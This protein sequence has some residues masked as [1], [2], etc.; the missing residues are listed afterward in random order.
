M[1]F[2]HVF[3][4]VHMPRS[5]AKIRY[6]QFG[7]CLGI[8]IEKGSQAPEETARF[9]GPGGSIPGARMLAAK[10]VVWRSAFCCARSPFSC[11]SILIPHLH[12]A[13]PYARA[14]ASR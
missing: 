8:I 3:L 6:G 4:R 11:E 9:K 2:Q 14:E 5:D 7:A 13:V 10:I 12:H 1:V